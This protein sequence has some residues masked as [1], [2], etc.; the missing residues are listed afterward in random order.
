MSI[1]WP[2]AAP[3]ARRHLARL[4]AAVAVLASGGIAVVAGATRPVAEA[5]LANETFDRTTRPLGAITV[6][7]DSVLQGSVIYSPTL[8]DQLASRGWGPIRVRAGVGYRTKGSGEVSSAYWIQRWRQEGWDAPDVVVNLGAN[9]SG[10]CDRDV[11]CARNLILQLVN[12]IGPGH[13]VWWPKITRYRAYQHQADTWNTALDQI[14]AERADFFTWDWAGSIPPAYF[15]WDDT[16][17]SPTGY[18]LR[19]QLMAYEITAD[20]ALA[21]RTGSDAA[22]PTGAGVASELVP[23]D[24]VRIIDTREDQ[25]GRVSCWDCL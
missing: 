10:N 4:A 23:I 13:R 25:M 3:P 1:V 9:D 16:H 6:I 17:L 12:T 15:A 11:A 2:V 5:A 24:P 21:S 14:A 18:R 22:L 7:G 19:S 20:L 8:A